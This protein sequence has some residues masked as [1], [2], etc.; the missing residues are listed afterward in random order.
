MLY[1]TA[2]F[3]M[4]GTIL[5]TLADLTDSVNAAMCWVGAPERSIDEVRRFVGN[6]AYKL[7]ERSLPDGTGRGRIEDVLNFY[8]PYYETHSR[9][10]TAPYAGIP[11]VL[12]ELRS[13]GIR[14]AVASNKPDGAVK[15][16]AAHY[17]PGLFDTAVGDRA[18]LRVKPAPDLLQVAMGVLGAD[19]ASTVYVGDSDVDIETAKNAGIPC[20]SV[21]WGFRDE[22]FLRENGARTIVHDAAAL[23]AAITGDTHAFPLR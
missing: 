2:I 18:G 22:D 8:R 5:D 19:A 23:Y 9:L 3:D 16:L 15:Q 21:A 7:I 1:K 11:E 17:F 12:S 4:D 13:N 20:I 10:K 14:L 6:G